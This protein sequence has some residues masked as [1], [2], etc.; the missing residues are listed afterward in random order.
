MT[1]LVVTLL[2]QLV[3]GI[4]SYKPWNIFIS[5]YLLPIKLWLPGEKNSTRI[6]QENA[7]APVIIRLLFQFVELIQSQNFFLLK[8]MLF[9]I[10]FNTFLSVPGKKNC[11]SLFSKSLILTCRPHENTIKKKN[12][13][14]TYFLFQIGSELQMLLVKNKTE[15]FLLVQCPQFSAC[16]LSF[17]WKTTALNVYS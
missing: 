12:L 4:Q 13:T 16:P 1:F 11:F 15:S 9:W 10:N 8:I 3:L 7:K 6:P 14:V 2:R 17:Y 5:R